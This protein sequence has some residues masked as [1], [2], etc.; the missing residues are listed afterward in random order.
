MQRTWVQKIFQPA[1]VATMMACIVVS[2]VQLLQL[3]VPTWSGVYLTSVVFL[4]ALEAPAAGRLLR[5]RRLG[6][7]ERV[8][9]RVGEWVL[10][11]IALKL[12]SYAARSVDALIADM[13]LWQED[14]GYFFSVEYIITIGLTLFTWIT[15]ADI[16]ENLA[17]LA[18]PYRGVAIDREAIRSRLVGQ[19]FW[20]GLMLLI[21]AGITRIGVAQI[22]NLRH[23][24]VPGIIINALLYFVLGLL[25]LSQARLMALRARWQI[26]DIPAVSD[27]GSRWSRVSLAFILLLAAV[28]LLLPTS[29]SFSLLESIGV[30]LGFI[31]QSLHML[32]GLLVLLLSLPLLFLLSLLPGQA[33]E[34]PPMLPRSTPPMVPASP[35]AGGPSWWAVLRSLI[36]WGVVIGIMVY[37]LRSYL[38]YRG[39]LLGEVRTRSWVARLWAFLTELWRRIRHAAGDSVEPLRRRL[40]ELAP[41]GVDIGARRLWRW[42]RLSSMN[43]RERIQYYYL[44]FQHRGEKAGRPRRK[45]ETPH[46]YSGSLR[47][48]KPEVEPDLTQ[49][50]DAFIEARYS[51]HAITGERAGLLH[52]TW[53][54][55]KRALRA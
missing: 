24:P 18:M 41:E 14:I 55:I 46:E 33:V 39:E 52:E 3:F 1:V 47:Q 15:A 35:E 17:D 44:S 42:R 19:F 7:S 22:L 48:K 16:H 43:P 49:L 45:G 2:V 28:A 27:V 51:L 4:A 13:A 25:L 9:F 10:I 30:I 54:R 32:A 31:L 23:P 5:R 34:S 50:T 40:A 6:W 26:Q 37:T 20:G 11:L 38:G 53:N 29:Y 12:G 8:S 36:F 21:V